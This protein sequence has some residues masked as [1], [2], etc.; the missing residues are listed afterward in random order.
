M[1]KISILMIILLS[2]FLCAFD[3]VILPE[4]EEN[5][6][7]Q[8]EIISEDDSSSNEEVIIETGTED[9]PVSEV[10]NDSE[11]IVVNEEG[12]E[13]EAVVES[14]ETAEQ[15]N[16]LFSE[17]EP[18][19][20][21]E[22]EIPS[23]MDIDEDQVDKLYALYSAMTDNGKAL[24]GWFSEGDYAPCDWQGITCENGRVTELYFE[25]GGYFSVFPEEI[26]AL[27]D[28]KELHMVDTLMRGPLPERLFSALPKL[29]VLDLEGNFL[30]GPI[31]ELPAAFE[32]YPMLKEITISD[33]LEDERKLQLLMD[34]D[35]LNNN[36][37]QLSPM[38]YPD[39]DLT[40][41]LDGEIP[42]NWNLLPLLSEIDL[43]GNQLTGSVPE[44]FA[45]I[46]LE[47]LNLHHNAEDFLIS[48]ELYD[49]LVSLGNP[50]IDLDGIQTPESS[51]PEEELVIEDTAE[52]T[53][54]IT[55]TPVP[56]E[57]QSHGLSESFENQIFP[58]VEELDVYPTSMSVII[59]E[60]LTPEPRYYTSTPVPRYFTATPQP[61]YYY[62][63][64]TPYYYQPQPYYYYPTATPYY[65]QP[66]PYYSYPTATPYTNYNPSWV[67]PTAT[68]AYQY[69]QYVQNWQPTPTSTPV[70]TQDPAAVLGFTY[71]LEAMTG[72]NIPMTWRYT[73]MSEYSI[74]YL[75][76]SGNL[77]PAFA[78][79]WTKAA[80]VCNASVCNATVT[81][82]DELL[83]Q[84]KFSL[85]LRVRDASGRIYMSDPVMME[86]SMAQPAPTPVPE[87]PKSFLGGFFEWLFGPLI[88][89]FRG[90]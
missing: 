1:K 19:P 88:R 20:T 83:Q 73:G 21:E 47:K 25:Y 48:K 32:F 46:P 75:D 55:E 67:Y 23:W 62:P 37:F 41:G 84:G 81:V 66:Q 7:I 2:L 86:V 54:V 42:Y 70:P 31:P 14:S 60:T 3:A 16:D 77:Y 6:E 43:S 52:P 69:P 18:I 71:K 17:P 58:P 85:Q 72:N 8:T 10:L 15:S 33:N 89:L 29:E 61:Y 59:V 35:Y 50:E 82:P 30:T 76:A 36:Y 78:M 22:P 12:S 5:F 40:P 38:D 13:E 49:H 45:W 79:E 87:Q 63:T 4:T 39:I 64:A 56:T 11:N 26:L 65:Y 90:K 57:E 44:S 27:R 53:A 80:D 34:Q 51:E 9:T 68:S 24:S 74:N 28:L